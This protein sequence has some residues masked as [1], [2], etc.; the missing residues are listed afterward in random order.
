MRLKIKDI[1]FSTGGPFVAV[2]NKKD[3][4]EI[5]LYSGDRIL[6]KKN[7]K[8]IISVI[9]L[10]EDHDIKKGE[11]GLFREVSNYLNTKKGYVDI[12]LHID[13]SERFGDRF[14][15]EKPVSLDNIS[16]Y[17]YNERLSGSI[18]RNCNTLSFPSTS[19]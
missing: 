8:Q 3:A 5:D 13:R 15:R 6:I 12:N 1:N 7:G 16:T 17:I 11:I 18:S 2:M 14:N 19:T 10:S 9:D 4:D